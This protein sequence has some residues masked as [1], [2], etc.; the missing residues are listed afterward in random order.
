MVATEKKLMTA[1][2]LLAMPDDGARYELVKGEL[3]K[4]APA[5]GEHGY[6]AGRIHEALLL[7]VAEKRLGL[8]LSADTGYKL[9]SQPDTVRA[10][11]VAFVSAGRLADVRKAGFVSGAPDLVVEV[12]SPSNSAREMTEKVEQYLTAGCRL[13]WIVDPEG[14]SVTVWMPD[15]TARLLHDADEIDGGDVLAGFSCPISRFFE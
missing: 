11:D 5:F 4:M 1:D 9:E 7:F 13:L 15:R 3:R 8:I 2:E 10:P 6:V 12:L 14:R